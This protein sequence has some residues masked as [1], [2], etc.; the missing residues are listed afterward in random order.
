MTIRSSLSLAIVASLA[1]ASLAPSVMHDDPEPRV[2][3]PGA[4]PGIAPPPSDAIVLF[5]GTS[6]EQWTTT[7]GKPAAWKPEGKAGGSMTIAPGSGSILT[8]KT[9][10]DAQIH[11]E[12]CE[13][14]P[15]PA[16][17]DQPT[18]QARGNSGVYIQNR[19]EV[20]VLDSFKSSTYPDGQCAAIYKKHAPLV[21]AC[22]PPGEWQTYDIVFHAPRFDAAGKKTAN[23]RIT[24]LHNGVLVQDNAEVDGATGSAADANEAPGPGPIYLQDH[25]YAVKYRNIWVRELGAPAR[26]ARQ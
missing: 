9:F 22:R 24:V 18:G 26:P 1:H 12:F 2:V 5:D 10:G 7:D 11:V 6:L 20:Q 3:T 8:K 13:P 14:D 19:Y 23:A 25:G 16:G 17:K 15:G 21:N 4:N